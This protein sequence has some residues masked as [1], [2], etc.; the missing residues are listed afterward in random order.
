MKKIKTNFEDV[1]QQRLHTHGDRH[2]VSYSN[3]CVSKH[4]HNNTYYSNYNS[5]MAC[6]QNFRGLINNPT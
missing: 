1:L 6:L 5:K 4:M 2:V 3:S